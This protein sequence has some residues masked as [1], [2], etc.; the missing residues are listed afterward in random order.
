VQGAINDDLDIIRRVL[1]ADVESFRHL[2]ERYQRPLL[3]LVRNLTPADTD[4][5]GVAQEVFLAAIRS[6][7]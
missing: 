5:Q 6:L 1:A 2:M 4:H 7:A 3:T